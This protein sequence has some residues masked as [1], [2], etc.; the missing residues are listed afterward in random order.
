MASSRE[1]EIQQELDRLQDVL[2][3]LDVNS[4]EWMQV[5]QERRELGIKREDPYQTGAED[6][7][8]ARVPSPGGGLSSAPASSP[9]GGRSPLRRGG[10]LAR[11]RVRPRHGGR[12]GGREQP[13]P[14]GA[15]I[16]P[17]S[18]RA[19]GVRASDPGEGRL[20]GAQV[21][22]G[23]HQAGPGP[24]LPASRHVLSDASLQ[25][26]HE[27]LRSNIFFSK[28]FFVNISVQTIYI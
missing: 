28:Y 21:L 16:D 13:R 2:H 18:A 17:P 19:G 14:G 10:R 24:P 20:H 8:Q 15:G 25:A 7:A 5:A 26:C 27:P 11:G 3:S 6:S 1:E 4:E 9:V 22:R 23:V 12:R